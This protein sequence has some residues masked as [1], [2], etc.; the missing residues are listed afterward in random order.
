MRSKSLLCVLFVAALL[1]GCS[2]SE[3][4]SVADGLSQSQKDEYN[5]MVEE[6]ARKSA[7]GGEIGRDE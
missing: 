5:A 4:S 6:E 3:P 1:I 2:S 7:A